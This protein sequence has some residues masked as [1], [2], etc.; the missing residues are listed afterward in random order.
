MNDTNTSLTCF[1]LQYV[2]F[3]I[4]TSVKS[5]AIISA[6]IS[7]TT[8]IITTIFSSLILYILA[9]NSELQKPTN[10]LIGMLCV[11]DLLNG[12]I[13]QPMVTMK[14]IQDLK[15][16]HMCNFRIWSATLAYYITGI[17]CTNV[18]AI[19]IHRFVCI[20]YL[21]DPSTVKNQGFFHI[22][23]V[24]LPFLWISWAI[25]AGLS[26]VKIVSRF[27]LNMIGVSTIISSFIIV[28][29]SY[30]RVRGV[31]RV[32]PE[33]N[34]ALSQ[35]TLERRRQRNLYQLKTNLFILLSFIISYV[36]RVACFAYEKLDEDA[37]F[38]ARYVCGRLA[39]PVTHINTAL[40]P[41]IY[42]WRV[43]AFRSKI[44]LLLTGF[45]EKFQ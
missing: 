22:F 6:Y 43:A 11:S 29:C 3:R 14:R 41:I 34:S 28:I 37:S 31:Y 8:S 45:L 5:S 15:N 1:G 38:S 42:C 12:L 33:M 10:L 19:S 30:I 40:H 7:T 20:S 25:W 9:K 16:I 24:A 35:Q 27:I 23:K 44:I 21:T 13:A 18:V 32:S 4:T 36:P 26:S 39:N 17:S 2:D